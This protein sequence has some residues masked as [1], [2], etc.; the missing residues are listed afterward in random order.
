M[1]WSLGT[2][3][4]NYGQPIAIQAFQANGATLDYSSTPISGGNINIIVPLRGT[5][6]FVDLGRVPGSVPPFGID[7]F[8]LDQTWSFRYA[9]TTKINVTIDAT[10]APTL[11]QV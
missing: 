9:T 4:N 2:V 6:V 10:G 7:A 11:T 3:L 1:S 8:Y 5:L